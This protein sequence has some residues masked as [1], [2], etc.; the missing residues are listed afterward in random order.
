MSIDMGS[1]TL[2]RGICNMLASVAHGTEG[3]ERR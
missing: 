2:G 3:G 1:V